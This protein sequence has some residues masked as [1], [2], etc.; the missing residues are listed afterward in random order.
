MADLT[1]DTFCVRHV[2]NPTVGKCDRCGR[3]FCAE[4]RTEDLAADKVYC[5]EECRE[6]DRSVEVVSTLVD[7]ETLLQGFERPYGA[8]LR[9]WWRSLAPLSGNIVPLAVIS[10]VMYAIWGTSLVE[11][12]PAGSAPIT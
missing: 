5:S 1:P 4:C 12:L 2:Q 8:G 9:T 7:D 6:A 10:G 11:M 3:S